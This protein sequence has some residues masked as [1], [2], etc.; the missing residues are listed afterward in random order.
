ML[1]SVVMNLRVPWNAGNFLTSCK[2]VS[3]SRRT[4][5]H[6]VSKYCSVTATAWWWTHTRKMLRIDGYKWMAYWWT[7]WCNA[8]KVEPI[9]NWLI[10]FQQDTLVHLL[11]LQHAK[12]RS[13][14]A[15]VN[16]TITNVYSILF[17]HNYHTKTPWQKKLPL[18]E[19]RQ[20]VLCLWF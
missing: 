20:Q 9:E 14:R 7:K 17:V 16:T 2:P 15:D 4:L 19:T 5:H 13:F 12:G 10:I 3:F 6:G 1:V 11:M 8:R 18:K